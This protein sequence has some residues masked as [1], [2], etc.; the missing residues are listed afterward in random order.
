MNHVTKLGAYGLGAVTAFAVALALLVSVSST[1]TVEAADITLAE[2]AGSATAAP[3]DKVQIAVNG[4]LAQVS[5]TGT[6][7]GVGGSFA[8]NDGQSINCSDNASCDENDTAGEI[9]V[10]LNVDG[11]SGEGYI[12][13][14]VVGVG[15]ATNTTQ[16]TKVINVSKANLVG[17]L[18]ITASPKTISAATGEST[19]RI[20]V[21]NAAGTPAGLDG[22]SVSLVTSLGSIECVSGTETQ[23]CSVTTAASSGVPNVDDGTAGWATAT[24]NGKGVEGVATITARLGTLTATTEVTLFGSAKNLTAEPDQGSIEIGGSVYVVL[25]VTDGAGNPVAGQMI[26][27]L[28]SKEVVGPGDKPVLVVTEKNTAASTDGNSPVGRG[29]SMD[30]PAAGSAKAIPACGD[31]NTD[32]DADT[33]GQQELFGPNT[34]GT[35]DNIDPADAGN[36]GEG[37]NANGQC[38][39]HVT[40]PSEDDGADDDATRGEHTLNFQISSSVKASAVIEVAGKPASIT[41]DAPAQVDAA[42]VTT[43]TVSVWDD[44]E[45][46]V[47]ITAVKVRKVDGGGLIEDEGVDGTEMTSNGQSKFTFIAPSGHGSSEILITA[48][49]AN[50]RITLQIGEAPEEP[51]PEIS[52]S[53]QSGAIGVL[54]AGSLGDLLGALDCGGNAGTTVTID[55]NTYVVGAPDVVNAA[56][57]ANVSF[58]IDFGGAYVNCR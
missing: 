18:T 1:P 44:E 24:L 17:S 50:T 43:I 28:T 52:V 23:A 26:A 58:P 32:V 45:V 33:A 56:F 42:S 49:D 15:G 29:Y 57:L 4:A 48:G 22:Q 54:N 10:D 6:G 51:A 46:L 9:Q 34:G 7:D 13:L 40:A 36:V 37:T 47:G 5:I 30:K 53:G 3:G 19:L 11:D 14:S 31:D 27:P 21:K 39:V 41:T 25:T 20:N 16:V 12:L 55:G 8:A 38:V 35:A 2:N